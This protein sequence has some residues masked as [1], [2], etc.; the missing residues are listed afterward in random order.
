[1]CVLRSN[2]EI[3]LFSTWSI[4]LEYYSVSNSLDFC[5]L[6]KSFKEA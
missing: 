3:D 1:M 4:D 6:L 2:E 5:V